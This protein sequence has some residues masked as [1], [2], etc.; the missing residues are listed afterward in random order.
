MERLIKPKRLRPGDTVATISISGGRAGDAD[1]LWRYQLGKARLEDAFGLRVV[2]TPHAL[3]GTAFLYAHPELR[4]QDLMWALENTRISGV[5]A[6]MG[7]DDS[8]RWLPYVDI[9]VIRAHPKV[10]MGYSDLTT[11]CCCYARAGVMSYYG[12]NVLTPLAQPGALDEYTQSAI[13]KALFSGETIGSIPP[14]GAHTP[15]DWTD[16]PAGEI[17][18]TPNAG[19]RVLAGHGKATGRLLGGCGGPLAQIMGTPFFPGPEQWEGAILL[20]ENG[21]PYGSALAGLH[22]WRAMA[23]AG[24]FRRISGLLTPEMNA[25]EE[26]ILL[27]FLQDEVGRPELAVLA[28]V[29]FG[30]RT[31]M[32]VLP[33]GA[34]A[35]I[36]C[37]NARL[38]ILESGVE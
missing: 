7:G 9:H 35:E 30:H 29:D 8:Y 11:L 31:P 13:R 37:E 5:I 12:P 33:I 19:Y 25:E 2:E 23:A 15:I 20:M 22:A 18:W 6:N 28:N 26:R 21:S 4:A 17:V 10:T 1:L 24:V 38:T 14:C 34:L 16:R 32:T 27:R 36:D 3:R